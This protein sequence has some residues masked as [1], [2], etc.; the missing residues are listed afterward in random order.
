VKKILFIIFTFLSLAALG[1]NLQLSGVVYTAFDFEMDEV[2]S[3][4]S[5]GDM[6]VEVENKS[7][8]KARHYFQYNSRVN[9]KNEQVKKITIYAP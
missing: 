3:L 7:G 2:L 5:N 1:A 9:Y 4:S 6:I 8:Q